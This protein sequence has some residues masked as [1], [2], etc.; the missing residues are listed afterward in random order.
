M[1]NNDQLSIRLLPGG[2]SFSWADRPAEFISLTGKDTV[3]E[4]EDAVLSRQELLRTWELVICELHTARVAVLPAELPMEEART[5]YEFLLPETSGEEVLLCD[6]NDSI[7]FW[8]GMDAR[9]YHFM[10][11]TFLNVVYRHPLCSLHAFWQ[12]KAAFGTNAKM[13]ADLSLAALQLLVYKDGA[14]QL[15]I[16]HETSDIRNMTYLILNSW[17]QLQLNPLQDI[18]LL[19]GDSTL[20]SKLREQTLEIIKNVTAEL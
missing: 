4:F 13:I 16:R 9:L 7:A 12:T 6:S 10:Q 19:T 20:C 17:Q 14:L 3:T 18:L 15:A 5:H 11:R 2:F 1:V 8:F